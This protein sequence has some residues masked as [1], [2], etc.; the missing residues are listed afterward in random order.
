MPK[1]LTAQLATPAPTRAEIRGLRALL[2]YQAAHVNELREEN[3]RLKEQLERAGSQGSVS[4]SI[5]STQG[6]RQRLGL[7]R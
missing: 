3:R 6:P 1:Q 2:S 4:D 7:R 5:T